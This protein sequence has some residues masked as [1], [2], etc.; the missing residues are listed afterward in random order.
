MVVRVG[1]WLRGLLA[2]VRLV[3]VNGGVVALRLMLG[4]R[5]LRRDG[6]SDLFWRP[7]HCL[8]ALTIVQRRGAGFASSIAMH[9]QRDFGCIAFVHTYKDGSRS[10]HTSSVWCSEQLY[11]IGTSRKTAQHS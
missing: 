8:P 10:T 6:C 4:Y 1:V 11:V 5:T 3:V 9:I 7:R 2:S